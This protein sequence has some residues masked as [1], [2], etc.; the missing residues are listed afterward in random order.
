MTISRGRVQLV[1]SAQKHSKLDPRPPLAGRA[2]LVTRSVVRGDML[3]K[4]LD[5]DLC[6]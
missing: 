5:P 1:I 2:G 6:G 3:V 4:E